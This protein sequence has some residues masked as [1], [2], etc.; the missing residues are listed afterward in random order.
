MIISIHGGKAFYKIQHPF[1]IKSLKKLNKG[2]YINIIKVIYDKYM[3][4]IIPNG[5][6]QKSFTLKSRMRQCPLFPLFQYSAE[7]PNQRI[8]TEE[9]NKKNSNREGR[10]QIIPICR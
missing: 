4:N 5:E 8:K 6:K 3:A 10:R 2:T 9:R 7:I 1:I